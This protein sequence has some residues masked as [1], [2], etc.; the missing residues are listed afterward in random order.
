[1]HEVIET[2]LIE[3][4]MRNPIDAGSII[5]N[6]TIVSFMKC[7]VFDAVAITM[8]TDTDSVA[9]F[10]EKEDDEHLLAYC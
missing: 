10:E 9:M 3:T 1:M 6:K 5:C 8:E 2:I 7:G 4:L